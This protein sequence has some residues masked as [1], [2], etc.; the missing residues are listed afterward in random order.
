MG[1]ININFFG[2]FW[3]QSLLSMVFVICESCHA[4][5][6]VPVITKYCPSQKQGHAS[7]GPEKLQERESRVC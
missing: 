5:H 2:L 4:H 1:G 6:N 3:G 7:L